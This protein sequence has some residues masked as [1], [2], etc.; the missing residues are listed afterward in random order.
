[1][2]NKKSSFLA[3]ILPGFLMLM[4]CANRQSITGGPRDHD[5]PKLLKA[6]PPNMTRNFKANTIQLDFDEYFKL[7][8]SFTEITMSPA[9]TKIPEYK[10][11]KK[12]LIIKLKDSLEKNTTYVINFGKAI[13]DVNESNVMKNFTYVFSTGPHIDSL[14]MSGMVINTTT[15]EREKEATVMLFTLKQDSLLFGKK[16]PTIFTT[17]DTSGNFSLN[18]LHDGKYKIYALKE[19]NGGNKIYDNDKE[20]IAFTRNIINLQRDTSNIELKLFKET[21]EKFKLLEKQHFDQD[22]KISFFFNKS[23]D[24]PSIKI[25]YPPDFDKYK[26]AEINKTN[27]TA[28][29]YMRNMDF[30][31]LRVTILDNNKPLDTL[32][33]RKGKKESF[34]RILTFQ[35]NLSDLKLKPRTP[36]IAT[37]SY[38]IESF[39]PA[40]ITLKED[41]NEVSNFTIVRDTA[42]TRKFTVDYKW[43]QNANYTLVYNA[44][45]FTDIYAEKNKGAIK[46]FSLNKP[47]NYSLLTLK[48]TVPDSGKSYIVQLLDDR[49][50]IL[51]KDV[52]HKSGPIVYKDYITGK[53]NISVV[54][55]DNKNGKWDSGNVH[56]RLLPENIWI[57]PTVITLRPNWEQETEIIIPKEPSTP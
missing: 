20:L 3:L 42:N 27:D 7:T 32:A 40:L 33:L 8:N 45:A 47:E 16:K 34:L 15:G 18:N 9:Q 14:S 37:A 28:T 52:I 51:R 19:I 17:T 24:N 4:G 38:P 54:Y 57:N 10:T 26:I 55:D 49:N 56:L 25:V 5:P 35:Y 50:H 22:G 43:K 6:T 46:H 21:P 29:V 1:M 39:D 30:D 53:Y 11:S 41:S 36:L 13:A 12:S 44:G 2:L 23:L 31:S 48:V